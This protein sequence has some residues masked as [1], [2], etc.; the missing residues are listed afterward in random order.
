MVMMKSDQS[1]LLVG[2]AR[3][4]TDHFAKASETKPNDLSGLRYRL[5][6]QREILSQVA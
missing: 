3:N 4:N 5:A 2:A 1:M 6:T